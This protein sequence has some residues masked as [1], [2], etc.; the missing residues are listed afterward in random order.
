VRWTLLLPVVGCGSS[1]SY[2]GKPTPDETL[3][4]GNTDGSDPSIETSTT[5]PTDGGGDADT[6]A[7]AD[8]DADTDADSDADADAD[9]DA[10]TDTGTPPTT[11]GPTGTGL[12]PAAPIDGT[13]EGTITIDYT[14]KVPLLGFSSTCDGPVT[15]TVA[16]ASYTPVIGTIECDWPI[17]DVKAQLELGPVTGALSGGFSGSTV[18]GTTDGSSDSGQFVWSEGWSG[19]AYGDSFT[20]TFSGGTLFYDAYDGTIDVSWVGP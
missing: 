19:T 15:V 5:P 6:D 12:T 3:T 14:F 2:Y 20:A 4:N 7:D 1:L 16:A 8:A 13:Y 17:L 11:T 9:T 10:D 18:S